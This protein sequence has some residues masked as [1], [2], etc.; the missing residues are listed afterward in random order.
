MIK[1]RKYV[2]SLFWA[3]ALLYQ[4]SVSAFA[5]GDVTKDT[6]KFDAELGADMNH[7]YVLALDSS[8]KTLLNQY[9]STDKTPSGAYLTT[10]KNTGHSSQ[11]WLRKVS[12]NGDLAFVC[13]NNVDVAINI[14]RSNYSRAN[15]YNLAG[16]YYSD[17]AL[18]IGYV[19]THITL[20]VGARGSYPA[21]S[22][23]V[24]TTA[25]PASDGNGTSFYCERS[26]TLKTSFYE[27]DYITARAKSF[28]GWIS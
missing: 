12:S 5:A 27:D 24:S 14:N 8:L 21:A 18:K 28:S 1:L 17:V 11:G 23:H 26:K 3:A 13:S 10:W 6:F 25:T 9:S 4:L 22:L 2:F 15:V 19:G 16:N 20:S 7:G